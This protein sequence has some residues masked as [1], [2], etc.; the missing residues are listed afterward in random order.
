M[1][2]FPS[3]RAPLRNSWAVTSPARVRRTPVDSG[4][5][6]R[7]GDSTASGQIEVMRFK[8]SETDRDTL[9]AFEAEHGAERFDLDHWVWGDGCEAAFEAE[10]KWSSTGQWW[11]AD[12]VLEVWLP[13]AEEEEE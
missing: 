2:S 13:E 3:I 8:L 6:K 10:I 5:S 9:V 7:R 4:P 11:I 1:A 12:V